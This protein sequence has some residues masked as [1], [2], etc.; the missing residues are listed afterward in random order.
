MQLYN[1]EDGRTLSLP[2]QTGL[3]VSWD[4]E[5]EA[6]LLTDIEVEGARSLAHLL[7]VLANRSGRAMARAET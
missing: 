4:P 5:G 7:E 6:L 2:T 1:L 3:P